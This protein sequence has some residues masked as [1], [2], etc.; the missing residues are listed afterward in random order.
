MLK[1][2]VCCHATPCR[3][4]NITTALGEH[5]ASIF[6]VS[7]I[8]PENVGTTFVGNVG[9]FTDRQ[10]ATSQKTL[11]FN[12]A[13]R[14]PNLALHSR[15]VCCEPPNVASE[16]TALLASECTALPQVQIQVRRPII[17]DEVLVVFLRF[18]WQMPTRSLPSTFLNV[19]VYMT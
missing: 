14:I 17:L 3:L 9:N 6:R 7:C 10:G 1:I 16:C 8:N 11:L 18:P 15:K 19:R 13:V 2:P 5:T 4:V 12:T